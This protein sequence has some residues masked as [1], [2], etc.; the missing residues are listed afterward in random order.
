MA[1]A[2]LLTLPSYAAPGL[3]ID[4]GNRGLG[5]RLLT[6]R[7]IAAG[8]EVAGLE[9]AVAGLEVAGLEVA[10]LEV[11]GLEGSRSPG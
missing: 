3:R 11:A 6:P 1:H 5:L 10:G 9:V 4:A 2:L 7:T 8:L